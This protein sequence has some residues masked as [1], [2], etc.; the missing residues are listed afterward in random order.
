VSTEQKADR[1]QHDVDA[2]VADAAAL[3]ITPFMLDTYARE[4]EEIVRTREAAAV[5][6]DELR[7]SNR[8]LSSQV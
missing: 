1:P 6:M 3:R 8:G 2:L 7:T 5:E 4:Y